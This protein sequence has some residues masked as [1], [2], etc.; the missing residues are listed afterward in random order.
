M[1]RDTIL[2]VDDEPSLRRVLATQLTRAGYDVRT[3]ASAEEALA[4]FPEQPADLVLTDLRMPGLDGVAFMRRVH[5]LAPGTPV[6]L[7]TAWATV[8]VA[9]GALKQGAADFLTKP[10]DQRELLDTVR[11]ALDSRRRATADGT[12]SPQPWILEGTSLDAVDL[13]VR[14]QR[15]S[16]TTIPVLLDGEPG[17]CKETLARF[18]HQQSPRRDATFLTLRCAAYAPD[19]LERELWGGPTS[20][21]GHRP[22][23]VALADGGTVFLDEIDRLSPAAQERLAEAIRTGSSGAIRWI[24]ATDADLAGLLRDGRFYEGLFYAVAAARVDLVPLRRRTEDIL[25]LAQR[26]LAEASAGLARATPRVT[27]A[28][29]AQLQAHGWP[30][31][32]RELEAV[33]TRSLLL[34][35]PTAETLDVLVGFDVAK[36]KSEPPAPPLAVSEAVQA[37]LKA[38]RRLHTEQL[39]A[40]QIRTALEA[41]NH[42]VT[43]AAARLGISR[44]SLQG[45]MKAY[46][47]RQR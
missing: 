35:A 4:A 7:L 15:L 13:R 23:R 34:A 26:V 39:E 24:T 27:P 47:L 38:V 43:H 6:V 29:A 41:E 45:K 2:V 42:N 46:G 20:D 10:Y 16:E 18:I 40:A 8:E 21:G 9:V 1:N 44:R 25:P 30:G 28:A 14:L 19:E 33:L 37:D 31:N 3:A 5:A 32:L 12:A 17:T 22:G 36:P 11:Q